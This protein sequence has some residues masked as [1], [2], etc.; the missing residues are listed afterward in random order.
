MIP[1][2]MEREEIVLRSGYKHSAPT[3]PTLQP[4]SDCP[5]RD[6]RPAPQVVLTPIT[7]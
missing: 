7:C 4:F 2:L 1:L 5:G 6:Q 3:E